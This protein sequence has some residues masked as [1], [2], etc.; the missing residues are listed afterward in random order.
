MTQKCCKF[1][2]TEKYEIVA[3]TSWCPFFGRPIKGTVLADEDYTKLFIR[4]GY[5]KI[6]ISAT[7]DGRVEVEINY[8][9]FC[10]RNLKGEQ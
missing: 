1:C 5:K 7:G 2:D 9:P 10:G 8:C 3:N 4:K 6:Y